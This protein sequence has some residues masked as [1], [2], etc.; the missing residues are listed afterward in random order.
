MTALRAAR[1]SLVCFV[2]LVLQVC[3]TSQLPIAGAI[4][5]LVLVVTIGAALA[6]GPEAGAGVG[7]GCG[8]V[9][10][11]LGAGPVGLTSLVY[12]MVGYGVGTSQTAV[13]RS[14]RLIPLAAALVAAPLAVCGYALIGEVI[15]QDLFQVAHLVPVMIVVTVGV[16][17]L[18]LPARAAMSW[19]FA[20]DDRTALRRA[21]VW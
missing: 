5:D 9:I 20:R 4:V 10:D 13:L 16:L 19:A 6:A 21:T 14:S 3:V 1:I 8:L 15:G 12:S 18:C 2:A 7:F 11:L 17:V